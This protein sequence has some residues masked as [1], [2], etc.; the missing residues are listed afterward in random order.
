MRRSLLFVL[1]LVLVV[2]G[3][4]ALSACPKTETEPGTGI[5]QAGGREVAPGTPATTAPE[6]PVVPTE[7]TEAGAGDEQPA[8]EAAT[9][10]E[11]AAGADEAGNEG[12]GEAGD[13]GEETG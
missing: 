3:L 5:E 10:E 13:T 4:L 1:C 12:G 6:E 2:L 9:G 8:G 11:G 7:G